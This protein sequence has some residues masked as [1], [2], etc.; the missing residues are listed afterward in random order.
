MG[1]KVVYNA[2]FGGFG[3]SRKAIERLAELGNEDA[4]EQVN[5]GLDD[6][7]ETFFIH[8]T[9]RHDPLLVQV[10]EELGNDADGR[11]SALCVHELSGRQYTIT[12]YDGHETVEEPYTK[13]WTSI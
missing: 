7:K 10:V 8:D 6:D 2:C 13:R 9:P 4:I 12:D 1:M 11:Y 3:L 5:E